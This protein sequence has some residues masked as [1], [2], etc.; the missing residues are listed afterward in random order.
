MPVEVLSPGELTYGWQEDVEDL[1]RYQEGGYHPVH[2]QDQYSN[3]RYHIVHKLGFGAYSTTWLAKD[4]YM[5]RYVA[6]KIVVAEALKVSSEGRILRHLRDTQLDHPGR[7]YVC[8][9]LDEF[10]ISGPNGRHLCLVSEPARCCI[11]SS[12][13]AS[14]NWM[15]P[16][17]IARAVAA[18]AILGLQYIHSRGVVH[19]G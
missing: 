11:A 13:E 7:G 1:T 3:E 17:G 2:I 4:Q 6:L 14:I 10:F 18:Q 8:S 16:M 5:N 12:K 19:G 9:I 15:F